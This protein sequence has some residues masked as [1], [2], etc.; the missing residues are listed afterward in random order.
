METDTAKL[1]I[2]DDVIDQIAANFF[3]LTVKLS[4]GYLVLMH[5]TFALSYQEETKQCK[6]NTMYSCSL[7]S[8]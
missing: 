3:V 4:I 1:N 2:I 8:L 6:I 5:H 7:I